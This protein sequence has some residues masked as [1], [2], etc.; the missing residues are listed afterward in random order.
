[1]EL[2]HLVT[3]MKTQKLELL[4]KC[5]I[6]IQQTFIC[7]SSDAQEIFLFLLNPAVGLSGVSI[8][9]WLRLSAHFSVFVHICEVGTINPD[10]KER[11]AK[12][13]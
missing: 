2:Q 10:S 11:G 3:Q 8:S 4:Q 7:R 12:V 5:G 13:M 1:M 6:L 9:T